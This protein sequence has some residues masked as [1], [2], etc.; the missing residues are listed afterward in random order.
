[1]AFFY[2]AS[3]K[4]KY[5]VYESVLKLVREKLESTLKQENESLKKLKKKKKKKKKFLLVVN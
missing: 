5:N 3:A 1:M 2:E 4:T